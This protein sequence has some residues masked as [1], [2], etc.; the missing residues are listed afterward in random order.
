MFRPFDNGQPQL[1]VFEFL[2][3]YIK[4]ICIIYIYKFLLFLFF[5]I[6]FPVLLLFFFCLSL[7][8]Y[9]SISL[10]LCLSLSI[11]LPIYK[12]IHIYMCI[13]SHFAFYLSLSTLD[14]QWKRASDASG[15]GVWHLGIRV[16][17]WAKPIRSEKHINKLY[18]ENLGTILGRGLNP[19]TRPPER[20]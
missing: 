3:C 17:F 8:L 19:G 9:I 20:L 7:S 11:Y 6:S 4:Y 14:V 5:I 18:P 12:Y 15:R 2:F 10:S 16:L 13:Y 1:S